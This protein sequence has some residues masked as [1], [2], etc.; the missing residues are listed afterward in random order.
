[1]DSNSHKRRDSKSAA[2]SEQRTIQIDPQTTLRD[3]K[4]IDEAIQSGPETTLSRKEM[5][6]IRDC[7]LQART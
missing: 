7:I 3:Q 6:R 1:M 2:V 5:D 4:W